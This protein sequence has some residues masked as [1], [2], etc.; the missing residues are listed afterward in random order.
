MFLTVWSPPQVKSDLR[1]IQIFGFV[2]LSINPLR[3]F[4][5]PFE[6]LALNS[7]FPFGLIGKYIYSLSINKN[8]SQLKLMIQTS[9]ILSMDSIKLLNFYYVSV[10]REYKLY[11]SIHKM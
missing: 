2:P 8:I 7:H 11:F 1:Y 10:T 4:P 3:G 6:S 5:F 9:T